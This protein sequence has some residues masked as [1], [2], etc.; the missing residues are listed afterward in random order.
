MLRSRVALPLPC[1]MQSRTAGCKT[2]RMTV[3]H[4]P[5][6]SCAAA[7]SCLEAFPAPRCSTNAPPASPSKGHGVGV[8]AVGNLASDDPGIAGLARRSASTAGLASPSGTDRNVQR[9]RTA[10]PSASDCLHV[11]L[12]R[13]LCDDG[14]SARCRS[15]AGKSQDN[16]RVD[17]WTATGLDAASRMRQEDRGDAKN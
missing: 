15:G 4:R 6:R 17:G 10:T 1:K 14:S 2:G 12:S 3:D 13:L 16:R 5:C 8:E 9:Q 7:V 11:D